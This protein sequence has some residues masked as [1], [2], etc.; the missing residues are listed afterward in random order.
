MVS[1]SGVLSIENVGCEMVQLSSG[2][3]KVAAF[4]HGVILAL[5]L[6]GAI[7]IVG[8]SSGAEISEELKGNVFLVSALLFGTIGVWLQSR[9]EKARVAIEG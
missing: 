7:N 6:R 5:A 1:Y 2:W 9:R 8:W 4:G 3:M